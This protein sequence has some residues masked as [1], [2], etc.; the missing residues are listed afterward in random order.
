MALK[1][2]PFLSKR[3]QP[4]LQPCYEVKQHHRRCPCFL[5]AGRR[6]KPGD[7][8]RMTVNPC[9]VISG[10]IQLNT[11]CNC[12]LEKGTGCSESASHLLSSQHWSWARD[13]LGEPDWALHG[14]TSRWQQKSSPMINMLPSRRGLYK[15]S[16]PCRSLDP[17][18]FPPHVKHLYPQ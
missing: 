3:I 2:Q 14:S 10:H 16:L 13:L 6:K 9:Q 5:W 17:G 8:R 11:S 15:T 18:L 4:S 1:V 7:C 12:Q